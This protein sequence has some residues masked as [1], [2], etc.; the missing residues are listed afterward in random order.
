[1]ADTIGLLVV[2]GIGRQSEGDLC[3]EVGGYTVSFARIDGD[4]S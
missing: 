2:H 3:R 1:M 4:D